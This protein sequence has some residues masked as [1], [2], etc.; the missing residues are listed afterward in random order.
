MPGQ[1]R[2]GRPPRHRT[3]HHFN[4]GP[5]NC[6]AKHRHR[7]RRGSVDGGTS[8]E[9]RTIARPN[10]PPTPPTT[11]SDA[12]QWRA[13]QLPGQTRGGDDR[14]ARVRGTS[15]EGRTIARP[16]VIVAKCFP[17]TAERTSME[18][19]TIA[20]PN[21]GCRRHRGRGTGRLQWRAG[22]LP[23][24]TRR[25]RVP[26]VGKG[27]TSMEGRTIA[28]PNAADPSRSGFASRV[29]QWRAGQLPGQTAMAVS[30]PDTGCQLQWRAG[31]LPGQTSSAGAA[32]R[33]GTGYFNGG[34]DNCPAKLGPGLDPV[35]GPGTSMEGRTIARPNRHGTKTEASDEQ[36][37]ME[38]RTIARPN[39]YHKGTTARVEL[40]QWRAGQLPGQ[41]PQG[42]SPPQPAQANFNGGPDNCPAKPRPAT[43]SQ[44]PTTTLQWR[45]GQLPGQTPAGVH[46]WRPGEKLQWRAGQL[47]GQ[48]A[49]AA[50]WAMLMAILQW[51]AG[52]LPGQTGIVSNAPNA[53]VPTSMEGRTIARPNLVSPDGTI[54][55]VRILQW[56]AGQLPGQ[57]GSSTDMKGYKAWTSMEGR[58]I[59]RPN[60][61]PFDSRM[62]VFFALQWRA[63]QLPGQT[64]CSSVVVAGYVPTSMEGRTIA[65]PN[66][67]YPA[68][69]TTESILQWRAGQLP[70]QTPRP[71]TPG[72]GPGNFNGG[73]DNC[74]AK[75]AS[76]CPRTRRPPDFN[77]GP[78]NCPAKLRR[79][80]EFGTWVR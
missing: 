32:P 35:R 76:R 34:P 33:W 31:Q 44:P 6:P 23:G 24:Q 80:D 63:G 52:Q 37:S 79:L 71:P 69:S 28:R 3:D 21:Q 47:P 29:L 48:T 2:H 16:N 65:R 42:T 9:G 61:V 51:R 7:L 36:T 73:P 62:P 68:T 46:H 27:V 66:A 72:I 38:G 75:R 55:P 20:R 57:T 50:S 15:M 74:P 70:G 17:A 53:G 14:R 22:Q 77:G 60:P 78:D 1:T 4:G 58:T 10:T 39:R 19:R 40:L 8:M 26:P 18:G 12:L 25:R 54:H 56:R 64:S 11:P 41:T 67:T 13:G 5:D 30:G 59:A 45:A 43:R 49:R